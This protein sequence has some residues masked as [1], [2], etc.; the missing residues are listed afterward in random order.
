MEEMAENSDRPDCEKNRPYRMPGYQARLTLSPSGY[1]MI[2]N[3]LSHIF[4][5]DRPINWGDISLTIADRKKFSMGLSYRNE[6][7]MHD[8]REVMRHA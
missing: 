2:G 3:L 7:V 5:T 4:D 8:A 6:R 1:P